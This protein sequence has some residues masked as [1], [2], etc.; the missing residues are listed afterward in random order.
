MLVRTEMDKDN[1]KWYGAWWLSP[2]LGTFFSWLGAALMFPFPKQ[3]S[4]ATVAHIRDSR[5][6]MASRYGVYEDPETGQQQF[7]KKMKVSTSFYSLTL[8]SSIDIRCK[9][10]R[11]LSRKYA[12]Y[13]TRT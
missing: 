13:S 6:K 4:G 5:E 2:L 8:R 12:L 7:G 10:G 11:F 3:L 1:P 9:F